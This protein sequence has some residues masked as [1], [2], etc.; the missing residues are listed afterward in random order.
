MSKYI[1]LE[2]LVDDWEK[3]EYFQ[4]INS[5]EIENIWSCFKSYKSKILK[6][7]LQLNEYTNIVKNTNGECNYLCQFFERDSEKFFAS[8]KPGNA[9]NYG[10]KM[11]SN[12]KYY[13]SKKITQNKVIENANSEQASQYFFK[14]LNNLKYSMMTFTDENKQEILDYFKKDRVIAGKLILKII[15]MNNNGNFLYTYKTEILENIYSYFYPE[16]TGVVT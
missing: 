9:T 16:K 13:C 4:Q 3:F 10:I 8:A 6:E 12:G 7:T 1:S 14:I 15:A 5:E 2:K 11:N